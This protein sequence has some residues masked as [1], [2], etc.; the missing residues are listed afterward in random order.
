MKREQLQTNDFSYN[1]PEERIAKYPLPVRN[2]SKLL[3][4]QNGQIKE[5]IF[6]GLEKYLPE[7]SLLVFNNTRVLAARLHFAKATGAHIEVFCL[8][9][10]QTPVEEALCA[11]RTCTWACMVGNLKRFKAGDTLKLNI[12]G[13]ELRAQRIQRREDDVLVQFEWD[14]GINFS[15]ILQEAGEVPLPPYLNRE[16][17]D[18][19]REQYQTVY[20]ER[21]GAVAAPTAGLHF[22]GDQVKELQQKGHDLAYL[23]LHVGAG[24]FKPVKAKKLVDH[25]MHAERIVVNRSMLEQMSKNSKSVICVGTTSLR[26][27][28]SLY[29]LAV[30]MKGGEFAAVPNVNQEDAYKLS[31]EMTVPEAFQYLLDYMTNENLEQLDFHSGLYIMPGYPWQ[32]IDGLITN[33]HQPQST[34]L[35]LIAAFIGEDWKKVYEYALTHDFRFLSYGDSS[36]LLR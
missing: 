3:V 25:S 14:G 7:D 21:E 13:T 15:S 35:A 4:Y 2:H 20:A 29:W 10:Y 9:P 22:V 34:L 30:K 28:E 8:E 23:T 18:T 11:T 5:D 17:E 1:L 36:L 16:T 33:F 26:S 24:T 31:Q 12:A 19:D 27:I 32:V 6:E